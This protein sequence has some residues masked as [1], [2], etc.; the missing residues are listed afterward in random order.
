ME[1][2]SDGVSKITWGVNRA[3]IG[4]PGGHFVMPKHVADDIVIKSGGDIK[5]IE[6][7]LG[8]NPGDLGDTPV[9]I[10]IYN[11]TGLRMP[12][13]NEPGANEFWLPGGKT[14]G[15]IPEAVIDQTPVS[16][17]II[18]KLNDVNL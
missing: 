15:G 2:F 16:E 12:S 17:A 4:P 18:S 11:P 1:K 3:E 5:K 13:G 7:L 10:D 6:S 9:R 8:L 14:S